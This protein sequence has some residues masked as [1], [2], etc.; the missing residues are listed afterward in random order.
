MMASRE[1]DPDQKRRTAYSLE[2]VVA[3][4]NSLPSE[5]LLC[6][7]A[8]MPSCSRL[9]LLLL[10]TR[11]T[12]TPTFGSART[13]GRPDALFYPKIRLDQPDQVG[14]EELEIEAI[15]TQTDELDEVRLQNKNRSPRNR[16]HGVM[17]VGPCLHRG[18]CLLSFL[19]RLHWQCHPPESLILSRIHNLPYGRLPRH[20]CSANRCNIALPIAAVV[21]LCMHGTFFVVFTDP[22]LIRAKIRPSVGQV[23]TGA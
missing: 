8:P 4:N 17:L 1:R 3:H 21:T 13:G 10:R 7:S 22:F 5:A 2:F 18:A 15:P 9:R 14:T 6:M 12:S 11:Y 23:N 16:Y 20:M 19:L